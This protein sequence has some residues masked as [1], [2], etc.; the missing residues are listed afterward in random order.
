MGRKDHAKQQSHPQDNSDASSNLDF[1]QHQ[2]Q[3]Q[4][5][6]QTTSNTANTPT[7]SPANAI[8]NSS[9]RA[10]S[11]LDQQQEQHEIKEGPNSIDVLCGRGA[12]V[13]SHAGN[14]LFRRVVE[15]NK[16]LYQ[17]CERH[18]KPLVAKS[19]VQSLETRGGRFL[20][21]QSSSSGKSNW[22]DIGTKAAISKTSQ[23]LRENSKDTRESLKVEQ[24]QHI[25]TLTAAAYNHLND[26]AVVTCASDPPVP[27]KK[28]KT[29]MSTKSQDDSASMMTMAAAALTF[30]NGACNA[31]NDSSL[32]VVAL[33]FPKVSVRKRKALAD[34]YFLSIEQSNRVPDS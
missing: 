12:A 30:T 14:L 4:D 2:Q 9:Y 19:I 1:E 3:G 23:A 31:K 34:S 10:S 32:S 6:A 26:T 17:E 29:M 13:N 24:Q 5:A 11:A 33:P 22:I 27:A 15:A 18:I 20:K 16:P 25:E 21:Q 8:S 7:S 28:Q